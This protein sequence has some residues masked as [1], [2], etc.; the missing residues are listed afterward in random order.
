MQPAALQR[1]AI[2]GVSRE[3]DGQAGL[4]KLGIQVNP[5]FESAWFQRVETEM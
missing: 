1:G 3:R 2:A 4:Y 5:R